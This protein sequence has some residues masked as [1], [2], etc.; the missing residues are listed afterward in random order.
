M[1]NWL[2]RRGSLRTQLIAWNIAILALLLGGLG[3]VIRGAVYAAMLASI[4]RDLEERLRHFHEPPPPP[5]P[6][7]RNPPPNTAL[8]SP[9]NASRFQFADAVP[10]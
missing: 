1:S 5:G 6:P 2:S 4:D 3:L 7:R 8:N 9:D 10:T